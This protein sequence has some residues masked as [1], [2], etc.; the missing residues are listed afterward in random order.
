MTRFYH[1]FSRYFRLKAASKYFFPVILPLLIGMALFFVSS[2][3]EGPTKIGSEILPASDFVTINS[4]DTLGLRSYTMY[5]NSVPTTSPV[6][7]LVGNTY[8]PYFGTTTAEFVSQ[9]RLGSSWDF[10]EITIDSVKLNLQLVTVHGENTATGS[11]LRLSEISDQLYDTATYYSNT[12]AP[13][14]GFEVSAQL[15]VLT[16]D[17]INNIS[18]TLPVKFGEYIIRDTTQLFYSTTKP[19][20]RSYFK[21]LNFSLEGQSEPLIIGFT[22]VSQAAVT[23]AYSNYFVFYMHD[24]AYIHYLYYLVLDAIHPNACFNKFERDFTTAEPDKK[25]G[26]INDTIYRDTLTYIQSLNG[27]YAR[28]VFPGL[29]SV[30]KLLS[31]G[32]FSINKARLEVPVYYDGDRYSETTV[33]LSLRL[34]YT[35]KDGIKSDVPDYL[36][37]VNHSFFDGTLHTQDSTYYFNIPSFIQLYLEDKTNTYKPELEIYQGLT[38]LSNAILRANANSKPVKFELTYTRF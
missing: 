31:N 2:C 1:S 29:D 19:D 10:G 8:D 5:N 6:Y 34:R 23:G 9:V 18:V 14:T 36:L 30:R 15:P 21:G 7:A 20:F 33:P 27:L 32:R 3:E 35:D 26:H 38:V 12:P 13:T 4:T 22:T 11:I 25:I 16:P 37:D 17:T 24:T 28:V